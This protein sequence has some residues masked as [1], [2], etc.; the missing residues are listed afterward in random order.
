M[1]ELKCSKCGG[2]IDGCENPECIN[3]LHSSGSLKEGDEIICDDGQHYC[4]LDC[5]VEEFRSAGHNGES[6]TVIKEKKR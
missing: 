2:W 3:N 5:L 1:S 4:E 6:A